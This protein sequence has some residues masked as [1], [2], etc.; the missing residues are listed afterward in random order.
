MIDEEVVVAMP[1]DGM[2]ELGRRSHE[3]RIKMEKQKKRKDWW[4]V[5]WIPLL[6]ALASAVAALYS[7]LSYF[8]K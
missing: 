7:V 1:S 2:L 4:A 6:G 3:A 8:E 5:N